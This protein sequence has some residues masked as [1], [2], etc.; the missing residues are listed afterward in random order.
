MRLDKWLWCAR[1]FKTRGLSTDAIKTGKVQIN[2]SKIKPSRVVTVG[3]ELVIHRGPYIW[4]ITVLEMAKNR[5]SAKDAALLY[6]E[7][8][9]SMANRELTASR[10]KAE[11]DMHPRTKGRPTKR[12]RRELIKFNKS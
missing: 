7:E 2:G 5:L 3:E 4:V 11:T 12:E 9:E 1:F 6:R 8:E 10:I